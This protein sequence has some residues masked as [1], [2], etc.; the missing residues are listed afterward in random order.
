MN[1]IVSNK[2]LR[3]HEENIDRRIGEDIQISCADR[4][5]LITNDIWDDNTTDNTLHI[6]CGFSQKYD[7]P[8]DPPT[9]LA[10]CDANLFVTFPQTKFGNLPILEDERTQ[11]VHENDKLWQC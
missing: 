3:I 9:C 2:R 6:K 1:H 5:K 10:K 8:Q 4:N 11:E 7:A